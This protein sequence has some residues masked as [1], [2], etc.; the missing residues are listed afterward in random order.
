MAYGFITK[1]KMAFMY[2]VYGYVMETKDFGNW[3]LYCVWNVWL[4][5]ILFLSNRETIWLELGKFTSIS[6]E[7]DPNL[8]LEMQCWRLL[9]TNY[10]FFFLALQTLVGSCINFLLQLWCVKKRGPFIVSL[11]VHI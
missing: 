2:M 5:S 11:Y 8:F 3:H 9:K 7:N 4:K 10:C 6:K 1:T